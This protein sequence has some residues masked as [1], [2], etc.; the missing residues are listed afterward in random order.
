MAVF[1]KLCRTE[2][3]RSVSRIVNYYLSPLRTF[4]FR[5]QAIHKSTF[6]GKRIMGQNNGRSYK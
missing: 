1:H 5:A 4:G 2:G 3:H 6:S